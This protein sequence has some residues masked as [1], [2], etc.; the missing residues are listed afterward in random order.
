M[1]VIDP[2]SAIPSASGWETGYQSR[3][4]NLVNAKNF[5]I[6]S[7]N[8]DPDDGKRT[9]TRL[10]AEMYK[11]R[12][13][14]TDITNWINGKGNELLNSTHAG[15]FYKPFSVPGYAM[16]YLQYYNQLPQS[17]KDKVYNNLY[18]KGWSYLMRADGSMDPIYSFT[19]FNSENF[20]WMARM[21]GYLFAQHY[22]DASKKSFFDPYIKNWIRALYN[23]GRVEWNSNNYWGHTLAPLLVLHQFAPA[24]AKKMAKAGLD[25]MMVEA[26]V[27]YLD[28]LQ[29]AGDV[30]A[31]TN[32]YKAFAGS[33]WG[34]SYLYFTDDA[35]KPT[36]ST[37]FT[38]FAESNLETFVPYAP[39]S[40][41]RPP[42]V[43]IDIA[44]RKYALPVEIRSAKPYYLLD[45]ENYKDWQGNTARSRKFDFET[46]WQ[47]NNY[48]LVSTASNR[49]DG[50]IGTY[51]E[52]SL[53]RLSVKG[54]NNGA[55]QVFGN[56]GS[57]TTM[58]GRNPKEEIGQFRNVM[59]RLVKG[60]DKMWVAIP[61]SKTVEY[62]GSTAFVDMGNGVYAAFVP[63]NSTGTS[64]AAFSSDAQYKQYNW[65][66]S[67][68]SLGGLALEVG[69]LAQY[70]SYANFKSQIGSKSSFILNSADVV[71]Y[72][73]TA[74]NNL[75]MEYVPATS[76][77]MVTGTTVNPAGVAPKVWGNGNFIDYSLWHSYEVSY[78]EDIIRQEWGSGIMT[79]KANGRGLQIVVSPGTAA[80]TYSVFTPTPPSSGSIMLNT[81]AD[82]YVRDG[83][84]AGSNYGTLPEMITK[85]NSS[86]GYSR[87]TY[88]K[89]DVSPVSGT[90]SSAKIR[91]YG[92]LSDATTNNAT[93]VYGVS[94]TSWTESGL[95]WN[96]KPA[97][98]S[99]A[100]ATT[101]IVNNT[102]AWYEWDV[103]AYV[104]AEK[105][106]GRNIISFALKNTTASNPTTSFASKEAL[107]NP[108]QLRLTT[109][110]TARI[111]YQTA[112]REAPAQ[113][114]SISPN[115][116]QEQLNLTFYSAKA[117]PVQIKLVNS[118]S[119]P[120]VSL[121]YPATAG[122]NQ[123]PVNVS[124]LKS[125]VYVVVVVQDNS[126]LVQKVVVGK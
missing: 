61:A 109:A 63:Y 94:T 115:P 48:T 78:G 114:L 10:L 92:N 35:N 123:V 119:Q 40:S 117:Q 2:H 42:Q 12:N 112:Q 74:G 30:R 32:A 36:Y 64:S 103:T 47:D 33:V 6:G 88:L 22:N 44:Q 68:G 31:K 83:S 41:Y 84:Y 15:S 82:S 89:F 91:L 125:G 97:S 5:S 43:V 98:G 50:T 37:N 7:G 102:P 38:G 101:S 4:N 25:W 49:P 121:T 23:S 104:N 122:E 126:R 65:S 24:E 21:G 75:K 16:Y 26:A 116:A 54:T 93:A 86:S 17:Q 60:L 99:T 105:A 72:K 20:N 8:S 71:T 46:I 19:E 27:H 13:N 90:I 29:A 69:T 51:S 100:L 3:L 85:Q 58:A 11:D 120:V 79:L 81:T 39:Y 95:S 66:F 52:Q 9:W 76:Y 18:G 106:A 45:N 28:G 67:T 62:S 59:L 113:A 80:I 87:E 110:S 118:L 34:Y 111:T 53:W 55:V 108:P 124:R 57:Y 73:S 1:T 70:G 56:A 96:N 107:A 77:T 14:P